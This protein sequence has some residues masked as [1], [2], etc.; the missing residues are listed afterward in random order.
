MV[1][2]NN[3]STSSDVTARWVMGKSGKLSHNELERSTMLLMSKSKNY[4]DW[5]MAS[6]FVYLVWG[7]SLDEF[8]RPNSDVTAMMG[9]GFGIHLPR[10]A[11]F[12][13]LFRW[14][15]ID[16]LEYSKDIKTEFMSYSIF[17]VVSKMCVASKNQPYMGVLMRTCFFEWDIHNYSWVNG[18]CVSSWLQVAMY[19][20]FQVKQVEHVSIC[21]L[22]YMKP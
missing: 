20:F 8:H 19:C 3:F 11:S 1:D 18:I 12:Q 16:Q 9:L 15:I 4:F 6:F 17:L 13:Q 21:L 22:G 10:M 14:M 7:Y 2:W 5:A